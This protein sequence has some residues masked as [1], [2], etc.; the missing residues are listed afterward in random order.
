MRTYPWDCSWGVG[1]PTLK[2][3]T[4]RPEAKCVNFVNSSQAQVL[5][6]PFV[7]ELPSRGNIHHPEAGCAADHLSQ[8]R[9]DQMLLTGP[10]ANALLLP[11]RLSW[12][13]GVRRTPRRDAR[14]SRKAFPLLLAAVAGVLC[15]AL[16]RYTAQSPGAGAGLDPDQFRPKHGGNGR[17]PRA[18]RGHAARG[19]TRVQTS[20]YSAGYRLP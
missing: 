6:Q 9:A 15:F 3:M 18:V 10:E 16:I 13:Q 1:T 4:G 17:G 5:R 12:G 8:S 20:H 14:M 7:P 2:Q 11:T 19:R